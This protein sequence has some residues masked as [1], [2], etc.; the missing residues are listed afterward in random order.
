MAAE[1][2]TDAGVSAKSPDSGPSVTV[3]APDDAN[4]STFAVCDAWDHCVVL[5][6]DHS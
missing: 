2:E 6:L 1:M 3:A 4:G 5:L